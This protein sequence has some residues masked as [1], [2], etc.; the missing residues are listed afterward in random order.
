MK[1]ATRRIIGAALGLTCL[2]LHVASAAPPEA[3]WNGGRWSAWQPLPAR[4]G[5]PKVDYR[6]RESR[7][8]PNGHGDWDGDFRSHYERPVRLKL[9]CLYVG[10]R[11]EDH[12]TTFSLRL[13]SHAASGTC[14]NI[15]PL[16]YEPIKMSLAGLGYADGSDGPLLR[17]N[18]HG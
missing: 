3:K 1:T 12:F 15:V 11:G 16:S 14:R 2:L 13:G 7:V 8:S 10:H 18:E 5:V 17:L 9:R 4:H 6:I